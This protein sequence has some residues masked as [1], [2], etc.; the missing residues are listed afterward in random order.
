[1]QLKRTKVNINVDG[2]SARNVGRVTGSVQLHISLLFYKNSSIEDALV[3]PRITCDLPKQQVIAS[4]LNTFKNLQ[5]EDNSCLKPG[6]IDILL[7]ADIFG[8]ILLS[9]HM[10]IPEHS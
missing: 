3:I 9:G 5:L 1:M 4:L 6:S 2:L 10:T 7:G 8:E